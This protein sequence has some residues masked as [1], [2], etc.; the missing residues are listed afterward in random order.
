MAR[1]LKQ[2]WP[3]I[4]HN[5]WVGS[6]SFAAVLV[7]ISYFGNYDPPVVVSNVQAVGGPVSPGGKLEISWK[8]ERHRRCWTRVDREIIDSSEKRYSLDDIIYEGGRPLGQDRVITEVE[9]PQDIAPGPATY[10][11]VSLYSCNFF[12]NYRPI[13]VPSPEVEFVVRSISGGVY[14]RWGVP[15]PPHLLSP[16]HWGRRQF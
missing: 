10:R 11:S 7:I 12:Q 16:A 2:W 3:T 4:R 6:V 15:P 8:L 9:V 1:T 5:L 14:Q 13:V